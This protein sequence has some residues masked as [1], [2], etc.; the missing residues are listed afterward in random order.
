MS[1]VILLTLSE[2]VFE[3][4]KE[5]STLKCCFKNLSLKKIKRRDTKTDEVVT[6]EKFALVMHSFLVIGD[7]QF[8]VHTQ[9]NPSV[10][11]VHGNQYANAVATILWDN[12][13]GEKV[14]KPNFKR[15]LIQC[16]VEPRGLCGARRRPVVH[17]G[18]RAEQSLFDH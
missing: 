3:Y 6:E 17:G 16:N 14:W 8:C 4:V 15:W 7:M 11:I 12:F 10:V 5:N 9:S 2:L 13:F 1:C 18:R